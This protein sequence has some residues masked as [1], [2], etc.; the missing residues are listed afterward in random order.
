MGDGMPVIRRGSDAHME[1]LAIR[2]LYKVCPAKDTHSH[3]T[4]EW[5]VEGDHCPQCGIDRSD[6]D[7]FIVGDEGTPNA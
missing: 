3:R 2:M 5:N 4:G 1:R 7:R 6:F